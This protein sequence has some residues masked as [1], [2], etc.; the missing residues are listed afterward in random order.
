[1][2]AQDIP[3]HV[4]RAVYMSGSLLVALFWVEKVFVC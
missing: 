3:K 2:C 1:M 4:G